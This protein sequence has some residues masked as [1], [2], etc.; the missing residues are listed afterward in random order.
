VGDDGLVCVCVCVW[1]CWHG[2]GLSGSLHGDINGK[3][4][5]VTEAE[6]DAGGLE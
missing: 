2:S 6:A 1:V 3:V 5:V 4:T